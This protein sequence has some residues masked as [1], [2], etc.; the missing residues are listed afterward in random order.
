M[1]AENEHIGRLL[2]LRADLIEQRR[3]CAIMK[4]IETLQEIADLIDAIDR[5]IADEKALTG[6]R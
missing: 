1:I 6:G 2:E 4:H 5:S 3:V